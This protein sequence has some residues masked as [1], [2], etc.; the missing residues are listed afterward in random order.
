MRTKQNKLQVNE[1]INLSGG[2]ASR[3]GLGSQMGLSFGGSRNLYD[4]LGYS[5]ELK[6]T[7]FLGQY[8]RH[9][10]AKAII[11]RPVQRA[12]KGDVLII[13]TDDD[14]DTALE[15]AWVELENKLKLKSNFVRLDKLTGLGAYGVLLLGF[16][17]VKDNLQFKDPVIKSAG[18]Q[19]MYLKPYSQNDA[20]ILEYVLD[21]N[22]P[23]YGLP[24]YY[25]IRVG[26]ADGNTQTTIVV[27]Y[28]RVIHVVDDPLESEIMSS[29]RLEVVYN[30]LKDLEKIV[31]GSAE[32]F[33]KGARPGYQASVQEGYTLSDPEKL[34]LQ[35]QFDEYEHNLRRILQL[36]GID[37][38]SLDTQVTDPKPHVDVQLMMISAVTNIPVRVLIGSE[39]GELSSGQDADEWNSHITGRREEFIEPMIIRPFV[40]RMID[41]G[42][43]PPSQNKDKV[44]KYTIQWENLFN[45]SDKEK[46]D[47]GKTRAEA[48]KSY[49][50]TPGV[51]NTMPPA[52]FMEF[53]LGLS[54]EQITLILEMQKQFMLDE[55]RDIKEA[56]EAE[57]VPEDK[58]PDLN[59]E[60]ELKEAE[61]ATEIEK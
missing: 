46:A 55:E 41:L 51:E 52:A 43:L 15:T 29:S 22:D 26:T 36:K 11:N 4:V 13:E 7:D 35:D 42:I 48:L 23:R 44:K 20:T 59:P 19:L 40:D 50:S 37:M 12:W 30:N 10:I 9:G 27:H 47:V 5:K 8:V 16:S 61:E 14:K 21:V 58:E 54:Q 39:R 31:G 28:S 17:D 33:W 2:L 45:Q 60:T 18:L 57:S 6:F 3:Y 1:A 53:C 25:N 32:M 24:L 56:E 34:K 38:K 49:A